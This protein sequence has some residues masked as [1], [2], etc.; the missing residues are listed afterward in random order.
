MSREVFLAFEKQSIVIKLVDLLPLKIISKT[1][2]KTSKYQQ[3]LSSII[4]VDIIEP[5]VVARQKGSDKFLLLDGHMRIQVLKELGRSEV[6]CL[7]AKDDEAFTYNKQISRL[8][9]V[10]ERKMLLRA[11]ERGVSEERL[12]TALNVNLSSIKRK[13]SLLDGICREVEEI[14]KDKD[15]PINTFQ[16][17][18]KM[19]PIRQIEVAELMVTM[20]NYS[21]SYARAALAATP[22]D[23]LKESSKPKSFKGISPAQI[24]KM[25]KEMAS[26]Q[27][28]IKLLEDSYGSDHLN[29]VLA[30]GYLQSMLKNEEIVGYLS[31]N[32]AEILHEFEKI[33]QA[34]SLGLEAPS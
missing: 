12:A 5:P 8:S 30:R 32:H 13:K 7:I 25:E 21:S 27:R 6:E 23:Q 4:D 15:C 28:E 24:A 3:I 29:L 11:I 9:A 19:K 17:L 33:S 20:N 26:L 14:L 1:V 16:C 18:K 31:K 34:V 22:Q 10:Q 2:R